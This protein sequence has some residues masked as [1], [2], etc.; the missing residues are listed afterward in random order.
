MPFSAYSFFTMFA[1]KLVACRH[2]ILVK[3]PQEYDLT[4]DAALEAFIDRCM[5]SAIS[6]DAPPMPIWSASRLRR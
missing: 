2:G 1:I 5:A 4:E 3:T 6:T